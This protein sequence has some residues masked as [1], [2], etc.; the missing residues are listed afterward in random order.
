MDLALGELSQVKSQ[1][2]GCEKN[3]FSALTGHLAL[4]DHLKVDPWSC[5]HRRFVVLV[6]GVACSEVFDK[7]LCE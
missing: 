6:C 3:A 1:P 2:G 5:L 7:L 4:A